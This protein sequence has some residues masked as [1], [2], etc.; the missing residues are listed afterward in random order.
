MGLLL[1]SR[2][3]LRVID[4]S[5]DHKGL[6]FAFDTDFPNPIEHAAITKVMLRTLVDQDPA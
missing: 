6:L 4:D 2:D 5:V 1:R 3:L